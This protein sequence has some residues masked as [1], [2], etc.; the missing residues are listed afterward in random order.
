MM[1]CAE[2]N[3]CEGIAKADVEGCLQPW[4]GCATLNEVTPCEWT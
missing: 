2:S 4:S 3:G 1:V